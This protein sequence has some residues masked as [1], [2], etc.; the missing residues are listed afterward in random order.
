MSNPEEI[1]SWAK[2]F[3]S[4]LKCTVTD[5]ITHAISDLISKIDDHINTNQFIEHSL[6]ST[7]TLA[8]EANRTIK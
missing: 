4:A 5:S 3:Q 2:N 6:E 7:A 8:E 1:P